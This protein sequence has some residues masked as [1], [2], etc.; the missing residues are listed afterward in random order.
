MST[1]LQHT[2]PTQAHHSP[3]HESQGTQ[4]YPSR[5]IVHAKLEITEPGDRDERE[6]DAVANTI[7]S[8]GK[9]ARKISGGGGSSGIAVSQQME[10]QLAQLQGG[11]RQMPEGLRNMMES[12]FGQ[13][14][15]QVRLHTDGEA[16]SM[17]SSIHAK[18]FTL[19]NDIYFN[20]GQFFPETSEGQ[21]LV[22]HELT[23]VVQGSGML[24]RK[25]G[26]SQ[27]SEQTSEPIT[28]DYVK[29]QKLLFAIIEAL[30]EPNQSNMEIFAKEPLSNH[31]I[32]LSNPDYETTV[33]FI[34]KWLHKKGF[35][36]EQSLAILGNWNH[37]SHLDPTRIEGTERDE[38]NHGVWNDTKAIASERTLQQL[39]TERLGNESD[40]NKANNTIDALREESIPFDGEK[41][42]SL[43]WGKRAIVTKDAKGETIEI[44]YKTADDKRI[45]EKI[46]N[47][48]SK[49]GIKAWISNNEAVFSKVFNYSVDG[50]IVFI[51]DG[52]VWRWKK[53][54]D[55]IHHSSKVGGGIGMWTGDR[56]LR[57]AIFAGDK[58]GPNDYIPDNIPKV[59]SK[60]LDH[61]SKEGIPLKYSLIVQLAFAFKENRNNSF[62]RKTEKGNIWY[63]HKNSKGYNLDTAVKQFMWHFEGV[64]DAADK[65]Q[66]KINEVVGV[67]K[68]HN[69]TIP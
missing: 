37:E 41:H 18:A 25:D 9:I 56:A 46:S 32:A 2:P 8:G 66:E 12:G 61:F 63:P 4:A 33:L 58:F 65:R 10:S 67:L 50:K 40:I 62:K 42:D 39:Y 55:P 15:S 68:K 16:A 28:L 1:T 51:Q 52:Q 27:T 69:I 29:D 5:T 14:F 43:I 11:G 38:Q 20:Q 45:K 34:W 30:I 24:C 44:S 48:G 57:L 59:P 22:A 60:V 47:N 17:S 7:M 19:G 53:Q 49:D 21:H 35:D 23:H 3:N 54:I 36:D 64:T 13:D 26:D 6:A 31:N